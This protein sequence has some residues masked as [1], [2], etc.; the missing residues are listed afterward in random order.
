VQGQ[1]KFNLDPLPGM[2]AQP[3]QYLPVPCMYFPAILSVL[4]SA[5]QPVIQNQ[6]IELLACVCNAGLR[7]TNAVDQR[8]AAKKNGL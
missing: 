2:K 7:I 3:L 4:K 5:Y 1:E 6:I 8:Q